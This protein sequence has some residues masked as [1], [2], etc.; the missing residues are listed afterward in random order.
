MITFMTERE[1]TEKIIFYR[2]QNGLSQR[3]LA[4]RSNLSPSTIS[5]IEK[6]YFYPSMYSFFE[7]CK[8]L[9]ISPTQ[10]FMT[11]SKQDMHYSHSEQ[12]LLALWNTLNFR[13]QELGL[14]L[15]VT[16]KDFQS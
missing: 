12:Q 2:T 7:I 9:N 6:K 11:Q 16:L 5:T 14:A 15:L 13:T 1:F 10:F 8:G 4:K 3:E